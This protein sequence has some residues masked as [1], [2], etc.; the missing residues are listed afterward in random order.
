MRVTGN[1][2]VVTSIG[3]LNTWDHQ[4]N[5]R[6]GIWRQR[7]TILYPLIYRVRRTCCLTVKHL[8]I[9]WDIYTCTS[10]LLNKWCRC[11][12]WQIKIFKTPVS[13]A[14]KH[15]SNLTLNCFC[16]RKTINTT[17]TGILPI[18]MPLLPEWAYHTNCT[19][20]PWLRP[21]SHIH[22]YEYESGSLFIC[23]SWQWLALV[24]L[25]QVEITRWLVQVWVNS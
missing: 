16:Q 23:P 11:H 8:H 3:L 24:Q 2:L 17:Y 14:I 15:F 6:W 12:L 22:K 1:T 13:P 5:V 7:L 4:C 20:I 25:E 9:A 21:H 18:R 10:W 19:V